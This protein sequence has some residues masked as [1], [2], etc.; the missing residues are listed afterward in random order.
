[1]T[2]RWWLA[3]L[4]SFLIPSTL[5]G[6]AQA[7][8][9]DLTAAGSACSVQAG[10]DLYMQADPQPTGTGVIDSFL[11][12]QDK[13]TEQG[14]NTDGRPVPFDEKT[15]PNFTR[16]L[17]LSEVPIVTISGVQYR[18]FGLDI[19]EQSSGTNRFL[20]LDQLKIFLSPSGNMTTTDVNAPTTLG[21]LIYDLDAT[22]NNWIKLD[23][24]LGSGSGSGDMFAYI[25]SSLFTGP[26]QYV[27]LYS[28][29]GL[30]FASG[31]GFEEWWVREGQSGG[32][33]PIP[34]P[35][36]LLLLG[37]GLAGL[38]VWRGRR[39]IAATED[40]C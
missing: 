24:S 23:Y 4:L 36:T 17:Q 38:P 30:N 18:E 12:I 40:G 39:P 1:M 29:F 13:G 31:A 7:A 6:L 32:Q 9:C 22:G 16:S 8:V 19:N 11:R 21:T 10:I 3:S 25:N 28:Q 33:P 15:D 37:S 20:S 5:G 14:Y 2:T 26:N 27:T 34:E 35:T